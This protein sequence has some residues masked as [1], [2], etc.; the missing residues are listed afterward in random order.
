MWNA[1]R[2]VRIYESPCGQFLQIYT[3]E[4]K[5]LNNDMTSI[6]TLSKESCARECVLGSG[7][8]ISS[9]AFLS[10]LPNGKF[11]LAA[12]VSQKLA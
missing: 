9:I 7:V 2:I 1:L 10:L 4:K 6:H 5:D 11:V 12:R 3:N 8:K